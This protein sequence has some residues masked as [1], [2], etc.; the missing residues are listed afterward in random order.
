[1]SARNWRTANPTSFED[2]M[3]LCLEYAHEKQRRNVQRVAALLGTS[4][5]TIYGWLREGSIPG[6][7]VEA[8]QHACGCDFIT[9]YLAH[10]A[11]NLLIPIPT[12][13]R[14]MVD[15]VHRLQDTLNGAVK[16][17]LGF[18]AGTLDADGVKAA[19]TTAMEAL[20]Y[21]RENTACHDQPELELRHD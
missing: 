16:A 14:V 4:H 7:K 13:K 11:G 19:T 2:A 17:L 5:N 21:Q 3:V 9:R 1:M 15:D 10:S 20:A 6:R 8:F 18:A 12:G